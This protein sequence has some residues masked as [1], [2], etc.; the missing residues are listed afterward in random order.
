VIRSK[1]VYCN[2]TKYLAFE[3]GPALSFLLPERSFYPTIKGSI[4][5]GYGRVLPIF[6]LA[7]DQGVFL[8]LEKAERSQ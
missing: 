8:S 2:P 5:G 1:T 7:P 6:S 4:V 3:M